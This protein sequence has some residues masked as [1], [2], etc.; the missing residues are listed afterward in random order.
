MQVRLC[1]TRGFQRLR[2]D[3]SLFFTALFGNFIFALIIGS[4][5][6]NLNTT[7]ASFYS[8]GALLFFAV[9]MNAFSSALEV[10][11]L[12]HGVLSPN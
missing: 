4:V 5:F 2:G 9:L 12:V 10:R 3:M 11:S 8:R 6:F 7:T 1:L